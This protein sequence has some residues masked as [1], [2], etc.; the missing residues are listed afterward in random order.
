MR[1]LMLPERYSRRG[2]MIGDALKERRSPPTAIEVLDARRGASV[3]R[4]SADVHFATMLP[5]VRVSP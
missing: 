2:L 3:L 5:T 1:S 4:A